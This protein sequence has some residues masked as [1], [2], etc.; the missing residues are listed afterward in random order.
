MRNKDT[1]TSYNSRPPLMSKSQSPSAQEEG[2]ISEEATELCPHTR[3]ASG[4]LVAGLLLHQ[5]APCSTRLLPAPQALSPRHLRLQRN[6]WAFVQIQLPAGHGTWRDCVVIFGLLLSNW[7]L[8]SS[9]FTG[10]S[11]QWKQYQDQGH[12]ESSVMGM[13]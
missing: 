12:G 10:L 4:C 13:G 5:A 9:E 8:S 1:Q 6:S 3:R 11:L 7:T 2:T